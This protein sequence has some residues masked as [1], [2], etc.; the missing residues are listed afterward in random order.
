MPDARALDS[1]S[2]RP[3]EVSASPAWLSAVLCSLLIAC[4]GAP[5]RFG[6]VSADD[7]IA[8]AVSAV[9]D[10]FHE[11][12]AAADE[13]RYFAHFANGGIFLGTDATERWTVEEFRAYAHPHFENGRAW[14][15]H[16]T[17]RA[18]DLNADGNIAF[19]DEDLDTEGLGPAR[20]SGVLVR[21]DGVFKIAQYNLALTIPNERF[22]EVKALLATP[23]AESPEGPDAPPQPEDAAPSP[24]AP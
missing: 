19:F 5:P 21:E 13:E 17:R 12:A 11:A 23:P 16:P 22:A 18:I 6:P 10:D 1:S 14:T 20:G 3:F 2:L 15:F 8:I 4:G 9:L 7:E 24:E